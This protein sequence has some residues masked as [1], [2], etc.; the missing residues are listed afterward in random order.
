MKDYSNLKRNYLTAISFVKR[1]NKRGYWLF[2]CDCGN[3]KVIDVVKVFTKNATTRSCG[4]YRKS[5]WNKVVMKNRIKPKKQR[6]LIECLNLCK[7]DIF[8]RYKSSAKKR[9]LLFELDYCLFAKLI[10]EKCFYC[11]SKPNRVHKLIHN[12]VIMPDFLLN[13]VDRKDNLKGYITE[14]CVTCCTFCNRAKNNLEYDVFIEW[15]ERIKTN[16]KIET[17]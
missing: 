11:N 2:K 4:C 8:R 7:K 10:T 15:I 17:L 12:G 3:E 9:N 6:T 5:I 16:A 13:G 1:E 14:N